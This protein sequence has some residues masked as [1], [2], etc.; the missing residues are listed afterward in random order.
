VPSLNFA[1]TVAGRTQLSAIRDRHLRSRDLI[2]RHVESPVVHVPPAPEPAQVFAR[3]AL[4]RAE[5]VRR[6][7]PMAKSGGEGWLNAQFR[8][9]WRNA[10]QSGIGA[11]IGEH[12]RIL[13]AVSS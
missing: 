8:M 5:E 6:Q 3:F 4:H 9:Y 7:S 12:R 13:M 10:A 1:S 2:H 11:A